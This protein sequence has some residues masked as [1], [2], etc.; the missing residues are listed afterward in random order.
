MALGRLP[1][2][3]VIY[4]NAAAWRSK[5]F[6]KTLSVGSWVDNLFC[7]SNSSGGAIAILE[8][9]ETDLTEKWNLKFKSSSME[10]M[11]GYGSVETEDIGP[12]WS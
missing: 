4:T 11:P 2:E 10:Y 12:R 5:G 8:S 9:A 6:L 7:V 3:H 1:I